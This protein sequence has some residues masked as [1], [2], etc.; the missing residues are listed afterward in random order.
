MEIKVDGIMVYGFKKS[1]SYACKRTTYE[2][3]KDEKGK[4]INTFQGMERDNPF[5]FYSVDDCVWKQANYYGGYSSTHSSVPLPNDEAIP[6]EYV[7]RID[8]NMV[9]VKHGKGKKQ[10]FRVLF[11]KESGHYYSIHWGGYWST[12]SEEENEWR[13]TTPVVFMSME[14]ELVTKNED[15]KWVFIEDVKEH[16]EMTDEWTKTLAMS[17][18]DKDQET[19]PYERDLLI[20]D[21]YHKKLKSFIKESEE[22]KFEKTHRF[23]EYNFRDTKFAVDRKKKS[24]RDNIERIKHEK[25]MLQWYKN[26]EL[27][28][29]DAIRNFSKWNDYLLKRE[30][31]GESK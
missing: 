2:D 11:A 25:Q 29:T 15:G 26:A 5:E 21:E 14:Y 1:K 19:L 3:E 17:V 12:P 20:L 18:F 27:S 16:N 10:H 30:M 23:D 7:D 4:V 6:I 9:V 8:Y 31:E 28:R 24:C 13:G 22:I